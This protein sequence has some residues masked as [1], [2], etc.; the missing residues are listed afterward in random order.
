VTQTANNQPYEHALRRTN[1]SRVFGIGSMQTLAGP[2]QNDT[3]T[4]LTSDG[5]YLYVAVGVSSRGCLLKIGSG[6]ND[7]IA[8]KIYLNVTNADREGEITWVYC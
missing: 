2:G 8:G 7:T 4:S 3:N 5:T 1:I 6:L